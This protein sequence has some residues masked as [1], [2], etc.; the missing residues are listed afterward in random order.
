ML[1]NYLSAVGTYLASIV[2]P[3]PCFKVPLFR[4]FKT[5]VSPEILFDVPAVAT[6]A[7]IVQPV[8]PVAPVPTGVGAVG[9][10]G[11]IEIVPY[12]PVASS[13]AVNEV[14]SQIIGFLNRKV[15]G[16]KDEN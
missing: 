12:L 2:L 6:V 4:T 1:I 8:V 14:H 3:V 9:D 11:V 16:V 15:S 10:F 13:P 5:K 7:V